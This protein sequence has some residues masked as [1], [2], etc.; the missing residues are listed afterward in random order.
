[1]FLNTDFR[2][3]TNT[4]EYET[5]EYWY[6]CSPPETVKDTYF[7][8]D[9]NPPQWHFKRHVTL[10]VSFMC[11]VGSEV[12]VGE[13]V[14]FVGFNNIEALSEVVENKLHAAQ[15]PFHLHV[16]RVGMNHHTH[17]TIFVRSQLGLTTRRRKLCIKWLF[18][19]WSVGC[20]NCYS[21][22][23]AYHFLRQKLLLVL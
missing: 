6:A 21:V 1:M 19:S 22:W 9:I 7:A 12:Q 4:R 17:H 16:N 18:L 11:E 10:N 20:S 2:H 23:C 3:A 13:Q 15:C 14:G 8:L 5:H